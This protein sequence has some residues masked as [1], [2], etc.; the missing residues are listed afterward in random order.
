M[1]NQSGIQQEY[2]GNFS[3]TAT[4]LQQL[5]DSNRILQHQQKQQQQQER[6]LNIH[7]DLNQVTQYLNTASEIQQ[8]HP[9]PTLPSLTSSDKAT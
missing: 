9:T 7:P 8:H 6:N 5:H 4:I 1:S 2:V 3:S